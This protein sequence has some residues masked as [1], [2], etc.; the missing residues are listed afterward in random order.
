MQQPSSGNVGRSYRLSLPQYLQSIRESPGY[1]NFVSST[2]LYLQ[3]QFH[4]TD[5]ELKTLA[6]EERL[7]KIPMRI[8]TDMAVR[9]LSH[10]FGTKYGI[11]YTQIDVG[12]IAMNIEDL[13][14]ERVPKD[15]MT[16]IHQEWD[17]LKAEAVE[18]ILG[19]VKTTKR[20]FP[21]EAYTQPTREA[22]KVQPIQ[23]Q[24]TDMT[25]QDDIN[26]LLGL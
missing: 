10:Q 19:D 11:N 6:V 15:K 12:Q 8:I 2:M 22:P 23:E 5:E 21:P 4:L 3:T 16:P 25:L 7:S 20:Q 9:C 1:R 17:A 18:A 13:E 26:K 24:P 14:Y